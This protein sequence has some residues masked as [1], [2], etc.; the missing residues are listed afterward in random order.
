MTQLT[1]YTNPQSRGRI[2]HWMMEELGEPY[3]TVW[4]DYASSM[5]APEFLA[6]NP[7]GKVPTLRHGDTIVTEAAAI[8]TYLAD[9]FPDKGLIPAAG[10]P[11][12]ATFYRWLFFAAGPVEQAVTAKSM[13]WEVPAERAPMLGF[14]NYEKTR[15]TLEMALQPGPYICG[16]Q[17]T[18]AD[19]YIGS[20]IHWG[21]LFGT[22]EKTPVFA[23]YLERLY[24]RPAYQ[25]ADRINDAYMQTQ[26][27]GANA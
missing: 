1:L 8:C 9:H 27:D 6:I 25:S 18:A 15:R 26:A 5:Q 19:V 21:T 11:A 7:M 17:F 10:S 12:R 3:E 20:H 22:V 4:L 13:N 23:A 16:E 2:V 24:A 14:G